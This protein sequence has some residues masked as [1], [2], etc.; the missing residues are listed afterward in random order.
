ML[1]N[2]N[3]MPA[4]SATFTS[5]RRL[6]LDK[7]GGVVEEGDPN[8]VSLL[9][10]AGSPIPLELAVKHGLAD[11]DGKSLMEAG[12]GEAAE[13]KGKAA[14]EGDKD[15]GTDKGARAKEGDKAESQK[16]AATKAEGTKAEG[17][18]T[19]AQHGTGHQATAHKSGH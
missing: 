2:V 12:D 7:D 5:S 17:T 10:A 6:Y 8:R 15:E 14:K 11:K 9:A 3:P 16:A 19:A 4:D 18:K 13:R 1:V